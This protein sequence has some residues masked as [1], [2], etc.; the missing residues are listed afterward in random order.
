MIVPR[1]TA[2]NPWEVLRYLGGSGG[3]AP[4]E[5]LDTVRDCAGEIQAIARP[6]AV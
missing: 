1:L 5:L 6:R 4:E 2:I 3:S